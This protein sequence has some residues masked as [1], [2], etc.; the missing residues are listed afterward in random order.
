MANELHVADLLQAIERQTEA[1]KAQQQEFQARL[2]AE[3]DSRG[4]EL[5]TALEA[6]LTVVHADVRK[7]AARSADIE[8]GLEQ[9]HADEARFAR[10]LRRLESGAVAIGP[11]EREPLVPHRTGTFRPSGL[12]GFGLDFEG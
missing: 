4:S 9:V 10:R 2:L 7:V 8:D 11:L 1:M 6:R 5:Q 3:I 12:E